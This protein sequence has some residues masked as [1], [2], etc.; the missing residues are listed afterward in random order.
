MADMRTDGLRKYVF[1]PSLLD[2]TAPTT[3]EL[4]AAGSVDLSCFIRL[5]GGLDY[6]VDEGVVNNSKV[7]DDQDYEEP[8]R[9][10][11]QWALTY[12]RKDTGTE[13]KAYAT[14]K[15]FARGYLVER[16]GVASA[17]AFTTGDK[18]NTYPVTCGAQV[19]LAPEANGA[20]WIKQKLFVNSKS[21]QDATVA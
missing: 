17:T 21:Y 15:R 13:D 18:V 7:C 16:F 3:D 5:D 14:L 1:V 8:G 6:S 10:K 4:T 12:V 9:I 2:P 19:P 11:H 20:E